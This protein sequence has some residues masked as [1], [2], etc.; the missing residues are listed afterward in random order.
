MIELFAEKGDCTGCTACYA[1]CPVSCITMVKDEEGFSYPIP[2]ENCINCGKCVSICPNTNKI[3]VETLFQK[4]AYAAVTKDANVWKRSASGGAFSEICRI[5]SDD[6]TLIAGATW[7]GF[8]VRHMAVNGYENIKPLCKSK[9][10]ASEMGNVFSEIKVWVETGSRAVFCG[11]PCQVAGLRAFLGKEY[12]NLLLIDFI[13][14]GVGSPRVF[15]E[16]ISYMQKI[17][18]AKIQSYE[19]RAKR[20]EFETDYLSRIICDKGAKYF[21]NDPYIQLFL[22]QDCLRPSCGKNCHYR[23]ENRM[24]DITIA[25]FKGLTKVFPKLKGAKRNYSAIVINTHIG[26]KVAQELKCVMK[27]YECSVDDIKEYNP[28]FYRQTKFSVERD[29][30]FDE[31]LKSPGDAILNRTDSFCEHKSS[32]KGQIFKALPEFVRRFALNILER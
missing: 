7:N 27:M 26:D 19:F 24:G 32:I 1:V 14:H 21:T 5:W 6:N 20:N 18:G 16:C 12:D 30:F 25:D 29:T 31:F 4:K 11:T 17:I 13:C 28:L 22:K 23:N 2:G 3:T 8:E 9:Y 10:I 15:R